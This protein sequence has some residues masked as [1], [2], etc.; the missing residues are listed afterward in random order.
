MNGLL[1][2]TLEWPLPPLRGSWLHSSLALR[3]GLYLWCAL[4]A[5]FPYQTI[6]AGLYYAI[7]VGVYAEAIRSVATLVCCMASHRPWLC[8]SDGC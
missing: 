8:L 1:T 7:A 3:V 4:L 2:L 5:M 6:D